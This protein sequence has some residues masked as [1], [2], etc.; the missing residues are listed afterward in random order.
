MRHKEM[1]GKVE[2][3]FDIRMLNLLKENVELSSTELA[4]ILDVNLSYIEEILYDFIRNGWVQGR[5]AGDILYYSLVNERF[6]EIKHFVTTY[7]QSK[8]NRDVSRLE[9]ILRAKFSAETR[10]DRTH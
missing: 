8:L 10:M 6:Q 9:N 5:I 3:T 4:A 7:N 2:P 1:G